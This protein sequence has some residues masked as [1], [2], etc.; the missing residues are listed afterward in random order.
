MGFHS[1]NQLEDGYDIGTVEEGQG[2]KDAVKTM[3]YTHVLNRGSPRGQES[4][5]TH[6][7]RRNSIYMVPH[8]TAL[9]IQQLVSYVQP[10]FKRNGDRG[11]MRNRES[12]GSLF[13]SAY[14]VVRRHG[15]LG[16]AIVRVWC[17][18]PSWH[19]ERRTRCQTSF[20]F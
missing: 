4:R 17:S 3:I 13:G 2:P 7:E 14:K 10:V 11:F 16:S 5:R 8:T 6:S 12:T 19:G 20:R 1:P 18:K 15:R 9:D